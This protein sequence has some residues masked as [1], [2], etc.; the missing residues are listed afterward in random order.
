M[1]NPPVCCVL[2]LINL[3]GW[4]QAGSTISL[5]NSCI[6]LRPFVWCTE[7]LARERELFF[8]QLKRIPALEKLCIG[9]T[10]PLSW[11]TAIQAPNLK[12]LHLISAYHSPASERYIPDVTFPKLTSVTIEKVPESLTI[13][14]F[15]RK[16]RSLQILELKA[17]DLKS[18][19][20]D[21]IGSAD[22]V[23]SLSNSFVSALTSKTNTPTTI[24]NV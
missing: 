7:G 3:Q 23:D 9:G 14:K 21:H 16:H 13:V 6:A 8:T 11:L 1:I 2:E 24:P 12:H 22:A 5:V 10:I 19:L 17:V 4:I 18:T 20:C 15:L